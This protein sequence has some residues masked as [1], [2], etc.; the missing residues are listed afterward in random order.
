MNI[1]GIVMAI[2]IVG[3]VGL[4]IAVFLSIFGAKFKVEVM[5]EACKS[6]GE[7]K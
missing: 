5:Y 3:G 4:L 7:G 6:F 2:A 1:Y